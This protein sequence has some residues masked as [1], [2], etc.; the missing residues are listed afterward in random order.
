[1]KPKPQ[2]PPPGPGKPDV[3]PPPKRSERKPK[4]WSETSSESDPEAALREP[5]REAT[6]DRSLDQPGDA[7]RDVESTDY[8]SD[9]VR[10]ASDIERR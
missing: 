8:E 5:E 7:E 3:G 10:K 2:S 6:P 4:R 9:R 1:M